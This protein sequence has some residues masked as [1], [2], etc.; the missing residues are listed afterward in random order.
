MLLRSAK[1]KQNER[2]RERV[3]LSTRCRRCRLL[4]PQHAHAR[5]ATA[6]RTR[7]RHAFACLLTFSDDA[8][9]AVAHGAW[10]ADLPKSPLFYTERRHADQ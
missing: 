9:H 5:S 7:E 1:Q 3:R 6:L 4:C 2:H 8:A 10:R